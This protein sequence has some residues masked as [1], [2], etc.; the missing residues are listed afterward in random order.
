MDKGVASARLELD[1]PFECRLKVNF[2]RVE[3]IRMEK[4]CLEPVEVVDVA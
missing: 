3:P 1:V 4:D 2:R